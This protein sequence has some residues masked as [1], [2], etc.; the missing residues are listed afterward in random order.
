ML[1]VLGAARVLILAVLTSVCVDALGVSTAEDAARQL[2]A[3]EQARLD[4]RRLAATV[5]QRWYASLQAGGLGG[6]IGE[7]FTGMH[8]DMLEP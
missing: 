1:C 6:W 7:G 5:L 2:I 8:L 3:K 4:C